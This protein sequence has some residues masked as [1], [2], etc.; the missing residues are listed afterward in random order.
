MQGHDNIT[1]AGGNFRVQVS[2][3]GPCGGKEGRY[4]KEEEEILDAGL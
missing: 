3:C 4:H 1:E 2:L